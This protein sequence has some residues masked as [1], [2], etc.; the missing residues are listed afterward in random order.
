M[1]ERWDNELVNKALGCDCSGLQGTQPTIDKQPLFPSHRPQAAS[2]SDSASATPLITAPLPA[3]LHLVLGFTHWQ[4]QKSPGSLP[5]RRVS[6]GPH[7]PVTFKFLHSPKLQ[8]QRKFSPFV[9]HFLWRHHKDQNS[10]KIKNAYRSPQVGMLPLG[11]WLQ[12][13]L[14]DMGPWASSMICPFLMSDTAEPNKNEVQRRI[15]KT[16]SFPV[17]GAASPKVYITRAMHTK[18]IS[19]QNMAQMWQLELWI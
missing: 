11:I 3:S 16:T 10:L 15:Q 4:F 18:T 7:I 17:P 5:Y 12:Q 13:V 9:W 19:K 2:I 8:E 1:S 6:H 14:I